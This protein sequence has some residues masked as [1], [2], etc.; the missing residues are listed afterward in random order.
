MVSA[1]KGDAKAQNFIGMMYS[2]GLGVPVND[3]EAVKWYRKAAE[4]DYAEAQTNLGLIHEGGFGV[5]QN[6][7]EAVKWY[8][9]AAEQGVADAQ[10]MLGSQYASG[11]GV[12]ENGAE[13]V[14]WWRKAAEQGSLEGMTKL[15]QAIYRGYG[16]L[17]DERKGASWI[18]KAARRGYAEAQF[19]NGLL[20]AEGRGGPKDYVRAHMWLSL[21][22]MQGHEKAA[23]M[24][25]IVKK[26]MT[27]AQIAEAQNLAAEWWRKAAEQ[28]D[29]QA[30]SALNSMHDTGEGGPENLA[31]A[32]QI[33]AL[34]KTSVEN[35]WSIPAGLGNVSDLV[36]TIRLRLGRDGAVQSAEI[37]DENYADDPNFRIMAE[38]ALQ[39]VWGASPITALRRYGDYYDQWRDVTMTFR[40]PV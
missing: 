20:Y 16:V 29:T 39:A 38:S 25:D 22:K 19:G 24:L 6:D 27:P 12:P 15:G 11:G 3:V 1:E 21:A 33:A 18:F 9:K 36:V 10:V 2:K 7:V 23:P 30:L 37:L 17:K 32:N 13:A 8:R 34:I 5:P 28:G 40:P 26:Q 35:Y 4:Q 14:K 31:K